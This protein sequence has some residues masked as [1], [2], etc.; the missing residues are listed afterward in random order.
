MRL[1]L[2]LVAIPTTRAQLRVSMC[3]S[4]IGPELST[5]DQAKLKKPWWGM[6]STKEG[7]DAFCKANRREQTVLEVKHHRK[8]G[9][10]ELKS[11]TNTVVEQQ[12]S[13]VC[14]LVIGV[15]VANEPRAQ[16]AIAIHR[17]ARGCAPGRATRP[18]GGA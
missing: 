18:R 13:A 11:L 17:K 16:Q 10:V 5:A 9:K 7:V 6:S 8:E 4:A 1:L 15:M 3:G 12:K 2:S 14:G